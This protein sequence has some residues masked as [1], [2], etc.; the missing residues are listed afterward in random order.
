MLIKSIKD[1]DF[2]NYKKPSMYI[3][4]TTCTFKC[5]KECGNDGSMCQ[6]MP[7]YSM[8]NIDFD[9][10]KLIQR[11]LRNDITSAIVISGLEP[12]DTFEDMLTFVQELRQHTYDDI[13]IYTGYNEDEVA[14]KIKQLKVYKNII[15]KFGRYIPN[16]ESHFDKV[17]EVELASL[18]QYAKKIS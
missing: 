12:F 13:V 15:V 1:E 16:Q 14:D 3:A 10:A 4:T 6:N 2:V 5:C 11:Y 18:N 17:L 9:N 7:I 8:P